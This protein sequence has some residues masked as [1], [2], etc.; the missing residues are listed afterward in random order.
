MKAS[1]LIYET[2]HH[3]NLPA[4][5]D[6]AELYFE[7][8]TVFLPE[9]SFQN[10]CSTDAETKWQKTVFFRQSN[11]ISNREFIR[12]AIRFARNNGYTHFHIS[13]LDNNLLYFAIGLLRLHGMHVSLTVHAVNEYGAYRFN[14]LR[15]ITESIA[16]LYFHR[17]IRHFRV[18]SPGMKAVLQQKFRGTS[19]HFIPS[20]FFSGLP[21]VRENKDFLKIVIPGGIDPGR[22]DYGF[23]QSFIR[24][25]LSVLV[26]EKTIELV[27]LGNINSP[28]G[29]G[30][31]EAL[32]A[33]ASLNLRIKYYSDYIPEAEY[34]RQLREAD[35]IWSPLIVHTK[36]MRGAAEKY[37]LSKSTGL[38]ADL[39]LTCRPVLVPVE[40]DIPEHFQELMITYDSPSALA[41][42][43]SGFIHDFDNDRIARIYHSLSFF[44][45]E[46]FK[47]DFGEFM[48]IG[49]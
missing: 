34:E 3:E 2:S 36:S 47:K 33:Y 46:N 32:N 12:D 11:D 26:S 49:S 29:S 42:R 13:T 18:L 9:I 23:V 45:K 31:K 6:L 10:I 4:L 14:N 48:S 16:K 20:R 40:F 28:Y 19:C 17:R 25:H 21:E 5:L 27:L 44:S 8:V 15:A 41:E 30:L 39:L 24:N 37:G 43:I 35:L 7:K 38:I 1:L 22:R